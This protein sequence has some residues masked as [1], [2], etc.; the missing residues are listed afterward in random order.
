MLASVKPSMLQELPSE[1]GK[2][3]VSLD[4][5][6]KTMMK[7][8]ED[9]KEQYKETSLGGPLSTSLSAKQVRFCF[10]IP[11]KKLIIIKSRELISRI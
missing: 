4:K 5:V 10:D 7:T 2:H 8:G 9:M 1:D 3:F 6:M 11:L